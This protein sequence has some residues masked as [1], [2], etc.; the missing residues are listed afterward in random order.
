MFPASGDLR[1]QIAGLDLAI[2]DVGQVRNAPGP[3]R[4]DRVEDLHCL[5]DEKGLPL[6]HYVADR[7][8]W[9]LARGRG[10]VQNAKDGRLHRMG[11]FLDARR[12][13]GDETYRRSRLFRG[14][15]NRCLS[16]RRAENPNRHILF[17]HGQLGNV[18]SSDKVDQRLDLREVH[19]R[20]RNFKLRR[21]DLKGS[22]GVV[23]FVAR[24]AD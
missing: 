10:P 8:E 5:Y 24:R 6:L 13:S 17:R 16:R 12:R 15:G 9:R 7:D 21:A 2:V 3:W 18:R 11:G 19:V 20:A 4:G 1:Q 14:L 22:P 23:I